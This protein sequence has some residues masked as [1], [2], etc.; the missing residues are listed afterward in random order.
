MKPTDNIRD[1]SEP[2][3]IDPHPTRR[4]PVDFIKIDM[5]EGI[6]PYGWHGF[7]VGSK[8]FDEGTQSENWQ[9]AFIYKVIREIKRE[10]MRS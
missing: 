8:L 5:S 9:W 3:L 4:I 6:N 7:I 1:R 10:R 2:D